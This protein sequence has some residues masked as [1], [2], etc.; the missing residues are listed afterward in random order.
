MTGASFFQRIPARDVFFRLRDTQPRPTAAATLPFMAGI[1]NPGCPGCN[2]KEGCSGKGAHIWGD[3]GIAD[4]LHLDND[5]LWRTLRA[6]C[7]FLQISSC[8]SR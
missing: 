1:P 8:L 4:Y 6:L 3:R 2:S 7:P 5:D